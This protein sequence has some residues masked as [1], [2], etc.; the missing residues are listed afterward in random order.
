MGLL[1][2]LFF[3][4]EKEWHDDESCTERFSEGTSITYEPDGTI[5]E[6]TSQERDCFGLGGEITVTR[7]GDDRVI[8]VQEGWG[9]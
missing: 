6:R 5:R 7:D 3:G 4:G 1:S 2:E 9:R 8:N